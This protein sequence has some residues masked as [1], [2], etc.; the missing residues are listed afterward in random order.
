MLAIGFFRSAGNMFCSKSL[1]DQMH[2]LSWAL[3]V[4]QNMFLIP[5]A[6]NSYKVVCQSQSKES[7]IVQ[8]ILTPALHFNDGASILVTSFIIIT[9]VLIFCNLVLF[10]EA[11]IRITA[12]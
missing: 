1:K 6:F 2:S 9:V 3:P 10:L 8:Y 4:I 12:L 5:N 11:T 7:Y